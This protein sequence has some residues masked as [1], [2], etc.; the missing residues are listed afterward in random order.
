MTARSSWSSL[1]PG[2]VAAPD[3]TLQAPHLALSVFARGLL[4]RLATRLYF[5][6][7][8][9][10]NGEDPVLALLSPAERATLV[11]VPADG[12]LRFD[13]RLAGPRPDARSSRSEE[14][15][16][17][18]E[19]T[20]VAIVG[21]GPAGLVLA[22][23]LA[24]ADIDAVVLEQRSR[25]Y[26]LARV[27]AGVLEH[28]VA[29]LIREIG[30]GER[31]DRDGLVHEGI[32]LQVDG[33][34]HRLALADA[35]RQD[36]DGLRAAGADARPDRAPRGDGR[37]RAVRGRG[38][39]RARLDDRR[40]ARH[41]PRG[42]QRARAALRDRRRLRRLPRRLSRHDPGGRPA[43]VRDRVPVRVARHPRATPRRPRTR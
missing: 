4:K 18:S 2:R 41:L 7:E 23:L 19:H 1:K 12:G 15:P 11:A 14:V 26:C 40:A 32:V 42:G 13:I 20:Q 10:A 25:D 37:R 28:D 29:Q 30:V 8:A 6:D 35:D 27:R 24:L 38:R 3:G 43:D 17:A 21:A 39:R 31:M 22:R 36:R 34:P 5:P 9:A 16:I 33:V